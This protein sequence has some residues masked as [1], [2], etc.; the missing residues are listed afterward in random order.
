APMTTDALDEIVDFGETTVTSKGQITVPAA[1]RQALDLAAGDR[2][3]FLREADG[4]VVVQLRK[5]R[6]IVDFAR[7]N[8]IRLGKSGLDLDALI[9]EA[10]NEAMAEKWR[11]S[12]GT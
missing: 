9:D 12:Q 5:R 3:H 6:S 8:P 2:L 10:I 7:A 4:R 11:R 1:L